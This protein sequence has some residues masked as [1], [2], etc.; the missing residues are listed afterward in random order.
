MADTMR[1]EVL[2]DGTIKST[3]DPISP[4]Q[5]Q[6][7]EAFMKDLQTLTGG[8][9]SRTARHDKATHVHHHEH[10]HADHTH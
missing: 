1:I 8:P 3:V 5:H 7:A 6:S 10:E 9:T 2:K 4:A